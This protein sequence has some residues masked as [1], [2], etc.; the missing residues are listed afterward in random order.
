VKK[1]N[2]RGALSVAAESAPCLLDDTGSKPA[3]QQPGDT[4]MARKT[5]THAVDARN[6][7]M[8]QRAERFN[9][10][11]RL[12]PSKVL[13]EGAASLSEALEAY[14]R[15]AAE[16]KQGRRPLV[17][18]LVTNAGLEQG[19]PVSQTMLDA[20]RAG[21]FDII[22]Q[23]GETAVLGF[24]GES[25]ASAEDFERARLEIPGATIEPIA[26]ASEV[27]AALAELQAS[28]GDP[29]MTPDQPAD[30]ESRP[31]S[32]KEA[33]RAAKLAAKAARIEVP[34]TA[35]Q[36]PSPAPAEAPA[37]APKAPKAGKRAAAKAEAEASAKRGE[38][39][40]APDFS[41][42]SH[43]P[44]RKRLDAIKAAFEAGDLAALK[45]DTT[46]PKSSSRVLICRY[47]DLC[48]LALESRASAQDIAA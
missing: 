14:D 33:R 39:P 44:F 27:A 7:E 19:Y 13:N 11:I 20:C 26:P 45:A 23:Q 21:E 48:I 25:E 35:D 43:K 9:V 32:K 6:D 36:T 15:L 2:V 22:P 28:E 24:P 34:P 37:K 18:A 38:A 8:V 3:S 1:S 29:N 4:E 47:R 12:S 30:I 17:Y 16:S 42:P 46:E 5:K 31:R 10:T 40:E 41:P